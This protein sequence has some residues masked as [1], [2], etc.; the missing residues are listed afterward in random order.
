MLKT[1]E[2]KVSMSEIPEMPE[3]LMA[4]QV[5]T[6][7][8]PIEGGKCAF[9]IKVGGTKFECCKKSYLEKLIRRSIIQ[10]L[11]SATA[12]NCSGPSNFIPTPMQVI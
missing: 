1:E 12:D 2:P 5:K 3:L 10:G 9:L 6:V 4:E 11:V 8:D 7:C